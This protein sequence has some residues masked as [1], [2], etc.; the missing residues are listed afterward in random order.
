MNPKII[1]SDIVAI[2]GDSDLLF[3]LGGPIRGGGDWQYD[4]ISIIATL[5]PD[6]FIACPKTFSSEHPLYR[7]QLSMPS[8]ADLISAGLPIS[9]GRSTLWERF[10]LTKASKQG[11]VIFWLPEED[12][13]NPRPREC[14][15]YGRDSYGEL[16]EWRARM[17]F[18][19]AK[20][21]VGG[22]QGFSG[23]SVIEEN[24][25]AMVGSSFVIH[26][27]L[28]DTIRAGIEMVKK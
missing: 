24:F 8:R 13:K 4:A 25:K 6:A 12:K 18:E 16:G 15:P 27:T 1:P 10:Y 7:F 23:L 28:E 11:C 20:V 2:I 17:K 21:V 3:F 14:G 5:Q 22:S 9:F 19:H 26:K